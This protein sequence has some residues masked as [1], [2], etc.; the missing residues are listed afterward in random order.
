[1]FFETK[2]ENKVVEAS[3]LPEKTNTYLHS[4]YANYSLEQVKEF[5]KKG[6]K[7][8]YMVFLKNGEKEIVAEFLPDGKFYGQKSAEEIEKENTEE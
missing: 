4:K 3:V 6:E 2:L 8:G 5:E 1:M 7:I